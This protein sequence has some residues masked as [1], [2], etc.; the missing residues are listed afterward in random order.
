MSNE[1]T[2]VKVDVMGPIW[3]IGWLFTSGL[4]AAKLLERIA[5]DSCMA[6]LL[7]R[8]FQQVFEAQN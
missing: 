8:L 2:K 7:R 6:I 1:K 4:S 5:G 3:A